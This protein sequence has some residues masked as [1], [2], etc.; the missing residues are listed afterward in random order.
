MRFGRS[1]ELR[2]CPIPTELDLVRPLWPPGQL[3]DRRRRHGLDKRLRRSGRRHEHEPTI[4]YNQQRGEAAPARS[5]EFRRRVR[6]QPWQSEPIPT[7][8]A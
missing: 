7:P 5:S 2:Y 3:G 1:I 6:R 4:R 8:I